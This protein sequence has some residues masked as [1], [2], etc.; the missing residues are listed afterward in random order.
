MNRRTLLIKPSPHT[1]IL[2]Q[3]NSICIELYY[4]KMSQAMNTLCL[5][6]QKF[7]Y[8]SYEKNKKNVRYGAMIHY[9]GVFSERMKSSTNFFSLLREDK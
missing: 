2:S 8:S 5:N 9:A 1:S 4:P 6:L 7:V 3:N